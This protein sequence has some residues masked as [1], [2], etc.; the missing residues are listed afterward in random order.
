[1]R[2]G[3]GLENRERLGRRGEGSGEGGKKGGAGDQNKIGETG[4]GE[5]PD[6]SLGRGCKRREAE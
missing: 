3:K 5:K 1:M 6:G 4:L 2:E